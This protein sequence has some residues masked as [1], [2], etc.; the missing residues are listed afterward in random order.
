VAGVDFV[1]DSLSTNVLPTLAAVD[2]F[3]GRRVALLVGGHDRGIDYAPLAEGL[4]GR[5]DLLVLCLPDSGPR[6]AEAL[7]AGAPDVDVREVP[8]LSD[9]VRAGFGW[10][11]PDGVVL[12][13]PAAPSFGRYRNYEERAADFVRSMESLSGS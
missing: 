11:R 12:L 1:D 4:T 10:A 3:G 7:R 8:D 9:G 5:A 13:S 6:I 2:A